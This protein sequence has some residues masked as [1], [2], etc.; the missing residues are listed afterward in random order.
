MFGYHIESIGNADLQLAGLALEGPD[1]FEILDEIEE[2]TLAPGDTT[3]VSISYSPES[4][5]PVNGAVHVMS[6]DP[7]HPDVQ[8]A[9]VGDGIGHRSHHI[10]LF[11]K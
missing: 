11:R 1:D 9:L 3:L 8:V 5:V 7:A 2:M 10:L 4:F 6:D